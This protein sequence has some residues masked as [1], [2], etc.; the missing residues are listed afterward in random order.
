LLFFPVRNEAGHEREV[1]REQHC[2]PV[3]Q[4]PHR[5]LGRGQTAQELVARGHCMCFHDKE[6]HRDLTEQKLF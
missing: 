5:G 3:R 1:L 2:D 4:R 6:E